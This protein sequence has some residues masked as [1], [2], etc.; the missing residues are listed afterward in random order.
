MHD[1][2][3]G[4]V[5]L[6]LDTGAKVIFRLKEVLKHAGWTVPSSSDGSTYLSDGDK[7]T[8]HGSGAAGMDNNSAWFRIRDPEGRR[9]L[10]FQRSTNSYTWLLQYSA[11]DRFVGG[12]PDAT[13]IPTA[14]DMKGWRAAGAST[15]GQVFPSSGSWYVQIAAQTEAEG[16]VFAFWLALR[17]AGQSTARALLAC[18][19]MD[20]TLIPAAD[21][22]P[23][24]FLGYYSANAY[25]E[26]TS[27]T[28]FCS[29]YSPS[30]FFGWQ[31][32]DEANEEWAGI[33][34]LAYS[35]YAPSTSHTFVAPGAQVSANP[36]S[37]RYPLLPMY[38]GRFAS[39]VVGF[40]GTGKF[41]RVNP[42]NDVFVY[43]DVVEDDLTSEV[44]MV[45]GDLL[46]PGWADTGVMPLA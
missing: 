9:E 16:D 24:I 7:I 11:L 6:L 31:R 10:L 39:T 8:H 5:N 41:L 40:K 13:T 21:S 22:D 35:Y 2:T 19:A 34:A 45:F 12:S 20:S 43:G 42:R 4:T 3:G 18:E 38:W 28:G 32:F 29:A 15:A 36:E 17:G 1:A 30:Y 25:P 37:G 33:T 26:G 23:C 14:T 46:L 44:Y 27:Y